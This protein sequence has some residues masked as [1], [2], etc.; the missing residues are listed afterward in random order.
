MKDLVGQTLGHYRIEAS[1]GSGGMGQIFRG[2]H[3][4]LERPAAIK[5]MHE[6]LASNPTFRARFLQEAKST[7]ALRD[8]H[9]VEIYEFGEQ[10]GLLYLVM[11]LMTEGTLGTLLGQSV[12]RQVAPAEQALSLIVGLDLV[13]QAAE[14]LAVAHE[15]GVIH[16]DIKPDNLLLKRLS[17]A[18]QAEAQY[19]LKISDFGLARLA[20]SSGLT[21][22]GPVGTP[23]YMSPEQCLDKKLDGRSDLY[24]LG[25]VLYETVT[26]SLPFQI[27]NFND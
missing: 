27:N 13:R 6:Y 9:I 19:Q 2:K 17:G 14:G 1:L 18:N 11:E 22:G 5:V 7:A 12:N 25:V 24:S 10:D 15:Q 4:Y 26:G 21:M 20:E 23:A 8:P 16:R 3:V